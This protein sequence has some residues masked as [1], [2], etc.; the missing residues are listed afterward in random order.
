MDLVF[1]LVVLVLTTYFVFK[2]VKKI[3]DLDT[4]SISQEVEIDFETN[5]ERDASGNLTNQGMNELV[6]WYEDDITKRTVL[7]S[8]EIEDLEELN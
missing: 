4:L 8:T 5:F 6:E 2:R 7:Q 3:K 1:V